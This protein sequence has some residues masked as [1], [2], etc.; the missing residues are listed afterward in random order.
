MD[1]ILIS[2]KGLED[3]QKELNELKTV[4]MPIIVSRIEEAIKLGDL[5]EN[6]EYQEAKD[7]QGMTAAR[8]RELEN[9]VKTAEV[10]EKSDG[11]VVEIGS[12]ITI[13]D[14]SNK[15]KIIEIVDQTQAN[16]LENKISNESPLGSAFMGYKKGSRVTVKLPAGD[17]QYTIKDIK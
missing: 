17:K 13:V 14:E 12:I 1:K 2:K 8:I 5:S 15:E 7:D 4:K 3:L 9:I 6:A 16:P 10:V 11:D